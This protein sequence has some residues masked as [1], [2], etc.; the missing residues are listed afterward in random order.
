MKRQLRRIGLQPSAPA[1]PPPPEP[2]DARSCDTCRFNRKASIYST[3]PH[4]LII[5]CSG[6]IGVGYTTLRT[7][8]HGWEATVPHHVGSLCN[9]CVHGTVHYDHPVHG[10]AV[11]CTRF[12]TQRIAYATECRDYRD[13]EMQAH[14][15]RAAEEEAMYAATLP[16]P[17]APWYAR[18]RD[19]LMWWWGGYNA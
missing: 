11:N 18:L 7:N 8:C 12:T 6:R 1:P 14:F 3:P 2:S 10:I 13:E 19:R 17:P 16:D 5:H 15:R 9:R 4:E